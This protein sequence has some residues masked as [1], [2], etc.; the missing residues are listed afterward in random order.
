VIE[1][2]A[3][4]DEGR[5]PKRP[6]R[7]ARGAG[8]SSIVARPS[9]RSASPSTPKTPAKKSPVPHR[10]GERS[11]ETAHVDS[12]ASE[13]ALPPKGR[14][15]T[16]VGCGEREDLTAQ[17]DALVRLVVG[18]GGEIAVDAGDRAFGRGA[19]VHPRASCIAGAVTRGLPRVAKSSV[20]L[21]PIDEA[22]EGA[23]P[24]PLR[25][26]DLARAMTNAMDRRIQGL[27]AAVARSREIAIG[28][29]AVKGAWGR[30]EA[31]LLV[32]ACDAGAAAELS[33]V[34][35]AVVAGRAVAWGT[36][37]SLAKAVSP[38]ERSHGVGVI[39]VTR[40]GLAGEIRSTVFVRD[41]CAS[42]ALVRESDRKG[43]GE[44]GRAGSSAPRVRVAAASEEVPNPARAGSDPPPSTGGA[45]SHEESAQ[46]DSMGRSQA[47]RGA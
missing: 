28:A 44:G 6:V 25:A 40:Q 19:H 24:V 37:G 18:P 29:D 10:K 32:V 46:A 3:R 14:T 35:Q 27:L 7:D 4:Q 45:V 9:P 12:L 11:E 38:S 31:F 1:E 26:D 42:A 21:A 20:F 36:K 5:G 41:A 33:E 43:R 30:N 22:T 17:E 39:A 34:R 23:A 47:E 13:A 2:M 15:R 8:R 16:C